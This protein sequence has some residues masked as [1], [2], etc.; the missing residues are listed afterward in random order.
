MSG[1][2]SFPPSTPAL[3]TATSSRPVTGRDFDGV[4]DCRLVMDVGD[5][6]LC[7]AA[8]V[9]DQSDGL[10]EGGGGPP[11]HGHLVALGSEG[12]G[13]RLPDAGPAAGDEG[14][15]RSARV[16]AS[17]WLLGS[18]RGLRSCW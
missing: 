13:S 1:C 2:E 8:S 9:G 11:G 14:R 4:T 5:H 7:V 6:T 17:G 12:C 10:L 16:V 18:S 3:L 15:L